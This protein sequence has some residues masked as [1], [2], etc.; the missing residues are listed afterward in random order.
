MEK[1]FL[2]G[3]VS[4]NSKSKN[5]STIKWRFK[6]VVLIQLPDFINTTALLNLQEIRIFVIFFYKSWW[7]LLI[8]HLFHFLFGNLRPRYY[9]CVLPLKDIVMPCTNIC[10]ILKCGYVKILFLQDLALQKVSSRHYISEDEILNGILPAVFQSCSC[11]HIAVLVYT[12]VGFSSRPS[13]C[14]GEDGYCQ[15]TSSFNVLCKA[16]Y[17]NYLKYVGR[18]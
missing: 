3:K 2:C 8:E 13:S 4:F 14:K 7:P 18:W 9:V 1:N 12:A 17:F 10:R 16:G 6:E 11:I 5:V 15:R